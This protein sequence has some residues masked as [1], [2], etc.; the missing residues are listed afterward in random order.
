M[1]FEGISVGSDYV[2]D[3]SSSIASCE[4]VTMSNTMPICQECPPEVDCSVPGSRF[5]SLVLPLGYWQ[6]P[7]YFTVAFSQS[8][9]SV[10]T[11][12]R[13]RLSSGSSIPVI[14]DKATL[15]KSFYVDQCGSTTNPSFCPESSGNIT[16]WSE[17]KGAMTGALCGTCKKVR[18]A[19][20]LSLSLST[21]THTHART[22]TH[23]HTGIFVLQSGILPRY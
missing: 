1:S 17:C 8:D 20:S 7:S 18:W 15:Q 9:G 23:T 3:W 4:N 16:T 12:N 6:D 5:E 2:P 19:L 22:H 10:T 14:V 11:A 13:R 21:H